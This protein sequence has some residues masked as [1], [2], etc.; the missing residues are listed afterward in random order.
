MNQNIAYYCIQ[1]RSKKWWAPLFMF[2]PGVAVQNS[3]PLCKKSTLYKDKP[4]DLLGFSREIVNAHRMK[5]STQQRYHSPTTQ[6]H[7]TQGKIEWKPRSNSSSI[8]WHQALS[9]KQSSSKAMG[10]QKMFAQNVM[11]HFILIVLKIITNLR[12]ENWMNVIDNAFLMSSSV[13]LKILLTIT[14]ASFWSLMVILYLFC[15]KV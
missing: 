5:Y 8:W 4:L 3:W 15:F 12:K 6:N 14:F 7:S 1:F 11:S 2:M 9:T 13:V 10:F